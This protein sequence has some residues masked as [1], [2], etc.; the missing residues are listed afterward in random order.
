MQCLTRRALPDLTLDT[1]DATWAGHW[2]TVCAAST[3][4]RM[5]RMHVRAEQEVS[6]EG[7]LISIVCK[8]S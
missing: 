3:V 6:V 5:S 4:V 2:Y 1:R 7:D 8:R